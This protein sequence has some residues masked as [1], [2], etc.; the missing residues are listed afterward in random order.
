MRIPYAY[1]NIFVYSLFYMTLLDFKSL[2]YIV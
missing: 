2:S 1:K